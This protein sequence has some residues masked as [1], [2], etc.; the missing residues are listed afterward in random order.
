MRERT[1]RINVARLQ[2]VRQALGIPSDVMASAMGVE[3]TQFY[4]FEELRQEPTFEQLDKA[5]AFM[6]VPNWLRPQLMQPVGI[7]VER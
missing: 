1:H 5:G 3:P 4:A 7:E 2:I 6:N